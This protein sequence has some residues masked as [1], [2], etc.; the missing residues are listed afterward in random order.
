MG[1][2]RIREKGSKAGQEGWHK[3]GRENEGR[4]RAG[5]VGGRE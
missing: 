5:R 3:G 1:A 2:Q 4:I